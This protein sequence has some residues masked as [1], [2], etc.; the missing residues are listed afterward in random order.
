MKGENATE[1]LLDA[2]L[3]LKAL[4]ATQ[5]SVTYCGVGVLAIPTTVVRVTAG[6]RPR[7]GSPKTAKKR[8]QAKRPA[9]VPVKRPSSDSGRRP[10][11]Q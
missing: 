6:E 3:A 8:Q 5:W 2:E 10:K 11:S 7:S 4:G 9:A 1:E